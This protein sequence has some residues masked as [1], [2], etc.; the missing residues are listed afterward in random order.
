MGLAEAAFRVVRVLADEQDGIDGELVAAALE[1]LGDHRV[2]GETEFFGPV[3]AQVVGR[4]LVD[5]G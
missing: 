4:L 5:L 2:K 3:G 1:G